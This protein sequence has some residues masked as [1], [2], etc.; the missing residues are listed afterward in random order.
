MGGT[1][2]FR[3]GLMDAAVV[4]DAGYRGLMKGRAVIVPGLLNRLLVQSVRI[5]PRR[6]V[7]AIVRF[8]NGRS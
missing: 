2:L 7:T 4:A 6:L 3:M 5:S 8:L 1:R